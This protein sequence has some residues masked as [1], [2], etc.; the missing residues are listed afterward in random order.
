MQINIILYH[1]ISCLL[2]LAK[3]YLIIHYVI[4]FQKKS[5]GLRTVFALLLV[6]FIFT[7][8]ATNIPAQYLSILYLPIV[9]IALQIISGIWHVKSFLLSII[10]YV[11]ICEIDFFNGALMN[12]LPDGNNLYPDMKRIGVSA[13]S[14]LM[15]FMIA[16][17]CNKL[18]ITFYKKNFGH[19]KLFI[20]IEV[21]VLFINIGIMGVFFAAFSESETGS[22]G[23]VLL[24]AVIILSMMLSVI[25]LIFYGA[26]MN[27][28]EYRNINVMNE[29]R[30][31]IQKEY[32]DRLREIDKETRKFRHD[33]QNHV[34]VILNLM[35]EEKNDQARSYIEDVSQHI[36]NIKP[37]I[38]SGNEIID[39]IL[40]EK[41][42]RCKERDIKLKVKGIIHAPM[43]ISDYD[44]CTIFANALDNAIE[45]CNKIETNRWIEISI[46]LHQDFLAILI[47][48]STD[49]P[50][51]L[52]S[53]KQDRRNHGFGIQNLRECVER[54]NGKVKI[55]TE[56]DKFVLDIV[57]SAF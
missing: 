41:L 11:C 57:V 43:I 5:A 15:I 16:I 1:T 48:N 7:I 25:S 56:E 12:M 31:E 20:L 51:S 34:Q 32:Y 22:F 17:V 4:G 50:V 8:A 19:K 36:E 28:K 14:L 47:S 53:K 10:A 46:G 42:S 29:K 6:P 2:D 24:P 27:I 18:D 21:G 44:I 37:V 33:I 55:R 35:K 23:G 26:I 38:N 49:G 30:L 54:N 52:K 45:A 40:N 39:T 3:E 9:L 13:V